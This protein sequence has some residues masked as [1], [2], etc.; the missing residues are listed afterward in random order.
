MSVRLRSVKWLV[1]CI[2]AAFVVALS[3]ITFEDV[4]GVGGSQAS[5]AAAIVYGTVVRD[6]SGS[7]LVIDEIWKSPTGQE[8]LS[9]GGTIPLRVPSDS[10]V[11]VPDKAVIFFKY[12]VMRS[13]GPLHIGSIAYVHDGRVG[14][15]GMPLTE[16]K[17]ATLASPGT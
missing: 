8:R 13:S 7:H 17:K 12:P 4:G 11:T 9:I 5:R 2:V 1:A 3:W 10:S 6:S 16:F 14:S 15:S